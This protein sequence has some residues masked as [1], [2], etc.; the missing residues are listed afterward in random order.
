MPFAVRKLPMKYLGVPLITKNIRT[1]ECNQLDNLWVKWVN[2]VK[3]K[4]KRIWEVDIEENDSD[5]WKAL[6]NLRSKIRDNV[7]QKIGDGKNTNIWF[8]KQCNVGPP[9]DIVPF[10]KSE[11]EIPELNEEARDSIVLRDGNGTYE[12]FFIKKVWENFKEEMPDVSWYKV[13]WFT[14]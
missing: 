12:R 4:G 13:I 6:L 8:E 3:L 7:W 10:R 5:T 1:A 2:I 9:C 14:Q 11:I